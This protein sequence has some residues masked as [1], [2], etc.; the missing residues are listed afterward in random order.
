MFNCDAWHPILTDAWW[1]L[2]DPQLESATDL[3]VQCLKI[4]HDTSTIFSLVE[5]VT[6]TLSTAVQHVAP[7]SPKVT[8]SNVHVQ[9]NIFRQVSFFLDNARSGGKAPR[10]AKKNVKPSDKGAFLFFQHSVITR[11]WKPKEM[12]WTP[13]SRYG[14]AKALRWEL[15]WNIIKRRGLPG[16]VV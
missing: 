4:L 5:D 16:R 9:T 13:C 10:R 2:V 1:L 14:Q 8:P 3:L 7:S 6:S 11:Y 15:F 12:L